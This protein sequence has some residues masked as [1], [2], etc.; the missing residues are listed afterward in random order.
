MSPKSTVL[1]HH[2]TRNAALMYE[3]LVRKVI[4]ETN[5]KKTTAANIIKKHFKKNTE[6]NKE[7]ALYRSLYDRTLNEGVTSSIEKYMVEIINYD[8]VDVNKLKQETYELCGSIKEH[9]KSLNEFFN[10]EVPDYK[11]L[12]SIYQLLSMHRFGIYNSESIE[13]KMVFESTIVN[14]LKQKIDD[15]KTALNEVVKL[16]KL[17]QNTL[18][19][20]F[21]EKYEKNLTPE[22]NVI[23]KFYIGKENDKLER[24]RNLFVECIEDV[25]EKLVGE[26]VL[27]KLI[28]CRDKINSSGLDERGVKILMH[29][30]DLLNE[31]KLLKK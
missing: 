14:H 10:K 15:R 25:D 5:H 2:K 23:L 9:Y 7:L 13:K 24:V 18:F 30:S 16:N 17:Q 12:A 31:L 19:K 11:V 22:Q 27:E 20:L 8:P 21:K 3:I 28:E 1:K 6:L 26:E 29:T 4:E